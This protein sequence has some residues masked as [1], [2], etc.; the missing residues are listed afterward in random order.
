MKISHIVACTENL[1]IGRENK[2]PWY[3]PE[4]LKFFKRMTMGRPIIMGRR[5][6]ESIGGPLPGRL[7]IVLTRNKIRYL[8]TK[9]IVTF[10]SLPQALAYCKKEKKRWG[11]EVFIIGG[12]QLYNYSSNLIDT[13]YMTCIR[14]EIGGDAFYPEGFIF[15]FEV[16]KA[17]GC[18]FNPKVGY[19]YYLK[20]ERSSS[21]LLRKKTKAEWE[22][23]IPVKFR[24][25]KNI[26]VN[27]FSTLR[28]AQ[29]ERLKQERVAR[30]KALK[31]RLRKK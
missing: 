6:F 15:D 24:K 18:Y 11:N 2:I 27:S 20:I 16:T 14:T 4:D 23:T 3:I 21:L 25:K 10:D 19:Y 12:S 5:T 8:E 22:P 31:E 13:I 1:L 9:G 30:Q 29:F 26:V 17:S 28:A 7:N